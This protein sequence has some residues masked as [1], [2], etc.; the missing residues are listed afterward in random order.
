MKQVTEPSLAV[1][2]PHIS[3]IGEGPVWDAEKQVICWLD[4]LNGEIHEYNPVTSAFKTISVGQMVGSFAICAD[5]GM[6]SGLEKG[7]AFIDRETGEPDIF[8]SPEIHIAGNRFNEGKC[9]PQGETFI[10]SKRITSCQRKSKK[11]V[12]PMGWRGALIIKRCIIS[13]PLPTR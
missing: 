10:Q 12:S 2:H 7:V 1:V 8:A 13:I 4:I 3:L 11:W 5:G 6:I 9:D